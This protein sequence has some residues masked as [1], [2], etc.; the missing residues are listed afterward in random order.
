[1]QLFS[2]SQDLDARESG[3]WITHITE[4]TGDLS[5]KVYGLQ[6]SI[7][8]EKDSQLVAARDSERFDIDPAYTKDRQEYELREKCKA[9]LIG[10]SSLRIGDEDLV[11][12][13]E[14]ADKLIDD[15]RF[16]AMLTIIVEAMRRVST[17]AAEYSDDAEKNLYLTTALKSTIVKDTSTN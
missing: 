3:A 13:K 12:S 16:D 7:L 2:L 6:S 1:M 15:P 17:M 4:T 10:W 14:T 8:R 11:Y 9:G 5:L